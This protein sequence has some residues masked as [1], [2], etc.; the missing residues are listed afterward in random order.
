MGYDAEWA[1]AVFVFENAR[2]ASRAAVA[3]R[4][5]RSRFV[6]SST[7]AGRTVRISREAATAYVFDT[8]LALIFQRLSKACDKASSP[9]LTVSPRGFPTINVG[10]MTAW[11]GYR[12]GRDSEYF[13]P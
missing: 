13:L 8:G 5:R 12:L 11:R 10:S 7:I 4:L 1:I 3:I 6:R 9:V 2:P